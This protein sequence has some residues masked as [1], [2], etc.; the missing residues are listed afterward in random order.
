MSFC[1]PIAGVACL[2]NFNLV[3][4][5]LERLIFIC[6]TLSAVHRKAIEAIAFSSNKTMKGAPTLPN[7]K[8]F[9]TRLPYPFSTL[10]GEV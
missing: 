5:T 9:K 3:S 4:E 6:Y 8:R 1:S 7:M 2:N 10:N